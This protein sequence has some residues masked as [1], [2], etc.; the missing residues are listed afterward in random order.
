M[1]TALQP[2]P[3]TFTAEA[4]TADGQ[5]AASARSFVIGEG[6]RNLCTIPGGPGL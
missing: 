4:R 3:Y 2:G 1:A 6:P 5:T